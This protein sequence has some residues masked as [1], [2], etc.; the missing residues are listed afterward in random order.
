MKKFIVLLLVSLF[1]TSMR[2]FYPAFMNIYQ[3]GI[4]PNAIMDVTHDDS[5][6]YVAKLNGQLV[7]MNKAT[8]E[9]DILEV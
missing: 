7:V 8:G 6:V 4:Y 3:D 9:K 5:N 1:C 2:A